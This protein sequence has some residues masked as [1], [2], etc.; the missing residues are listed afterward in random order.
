MDGAPVLGHMPALL[1]F[2]VSLDSLL[3]ILVPPLRPD[4]ELS[5]RTPAW[6]PLPDVLGKAPLQILDP[7]PRRAGICGGC[8]FKQPGP[9]ARDNGQ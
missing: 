5:Y 8:C 2:K 4:S 1:G 3:Q 6:P 9:W 7:T